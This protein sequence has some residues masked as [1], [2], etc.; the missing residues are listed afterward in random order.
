[1]FSLWILYCMVDLLGI[2]FPKGRKYQIV[3]TQ[4]ECHNRRP[5]VWAN[6]WQIWVSFSFEVCWGQL[7][8]VAPILGCSLKL[9]SSW[10]AGWHLKGFDL[11]FLSGAHLGYMPPQLK[12]KTKQNLRFRVVWASCLAWIS[13]S[14]YNYLDQN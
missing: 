9:S 6:R 8:F 13:C 11:A 1:M 10:L 5:I 3:K 4:I 12:T 7:E 14:F 2:A